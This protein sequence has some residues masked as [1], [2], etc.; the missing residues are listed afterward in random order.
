MPSSFRLVWRSLHCNSNNEEKIASIKHV[1]YAM[2]YVVSWMDINV[3]SKFQN[4]IDQLIKFRFNEQSVQFVADIH[5]FIGKSWQFREHLNL[6][7]KIEYI[8]CEIWNNTSFFNPNSLLY[9]NMIFIVIINFYIICHY[10]G[11]FQDVL[12]K[13][14]IVR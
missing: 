9:F 5:Y 13:C 11:C 7:L 12:I 10:V 1:L 4:S 6:E 14:I 8:L 3:D 2:W